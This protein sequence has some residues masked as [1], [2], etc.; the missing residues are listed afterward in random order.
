[1]TPLFMAGNEKMVGSAKPPIPS[2][3]VP[4]L[5]NSRRVGQ[6]QLLMAPTRIKGSQ[7]PGR[8]YGV[9]DDNINNYVFG[10]ALF[11]P[12]GALALMYEGSGSFG[13]V[14]VQ[15]QYNKRLQPAL[16]Y[17]GASGTNVYQRCYDF[18]QLGGL[19]IT[20]GGITC[21][22]TTTS[23]GDNGNLYQVTN[24]LDGNRTQNYAYDS[25]NRITTG[26]TNGTNWGQSF[27][28]DAWGNLTNVNNVSGK[29]Q[30]GGLSAA[31]ASTKNQLNGYVYDA[32]GNLSNDE[33]GHVFT[34]D[35]E[36]RIATV[37]GVA[38]TYDGDGKRVEKSSGTLYWNGV[39]TDAISESDLSGNITA[40][41]IFFNGSRVARV[42][43]PSLLVHHFLR[44]HLGSSRIS[45]TGLT[46]ATFAVEQDMD[47]TPY[48]I[49]VGTAPVDP[50]QFTGKEY[51]GESG[52]DYFDAR[53]YASIMGRF[54]QPDP[55]GPSA[56]DPS[57]PQSWNLYAYVL[58]N[59][60]IFIDPDGLDCVYLNDAGDG[61][62]SIDQNSNFSECSGGGGYWIEGAVNSS[63]QVKVN[64]DTGIVTGYG[65]DSNGNAEFSEAGA[66][67]SNA[68]GAWTQTFGTGVSLNL[69]DAANNPT[70]TPRQAATQYCQQHGQLSFNIP[71]TKIPVTISAS[72]TLGPANFSATNDINTVFPVIPWPEWLGGGASIDITINSPSEPSSN[73]NVGFGKNLSIGYFT[74]PSGPQ[75]LSLS[76]GPSVGPPIN[77]SVP[78]NNACGM[79]VGG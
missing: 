40:E 44:D 62:Q 79:L 74:T 12:N 58:N 10:N 65:F 73:P 19:N 29:T 70:Q 77:V 66:A 76:V 37:A 15:I 13:G 1:M 38:Y 49:A 68:W 8:E 27:V 75:G 3:E 25:L 71:F 6:P 46:Q 69:L 2:S 21:S 41:Y 4:T 34:Y 24:L 51:D 18:H 43:R 17:A 22:S 59:P 45:W 35:A 32:A 53:H 47:Y 56:T 61:V 5:R 33:L 55:A 31:P 11:A 28:I 52:A 14:G 78:T 7:P 9:I 39:G 30:P 16:E 63:S 57:N 67:G 26:Y 48:G 23:P 72:T 20:Y 54:L 60:L 36:N 42:D 64:S 50:F